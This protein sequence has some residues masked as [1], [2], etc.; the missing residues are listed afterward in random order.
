MRDGWGDV[1]LTDT[2]PGSHLSYKEKLRRTKT[3][4]VDINKEQIDERCYTSIKSEDRTMEEDAFEKIKDLIYGLKDRLD[5][6]DFGAAEDS[7]KSKLY[8]TL[9][10]LENIAD[11]F[12]KGLKE[13]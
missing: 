4:P 3:I 2:I 11:N 5:D 8:N 9:Y 13:R 6:Y 1:M 7:E 10:E 12:S